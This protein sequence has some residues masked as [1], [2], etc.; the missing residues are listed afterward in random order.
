MPDFPGSIVA[1]SVSGQVSSEDI[2]DVLIP[3]VHERRAKYDSLRLLFHFTPEFRRFTTT[4]AW[5]D[6]T[7]GLHHLEDFDRV[8]IITDVAWLRRLAESLSKTRPDAVRR[9]AAKE[10]AAA[11]DWICSE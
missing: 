8:A 2:G 10:L 7:V 9:F 11:K 1:A 4:A 3:A 6:Q 5:D